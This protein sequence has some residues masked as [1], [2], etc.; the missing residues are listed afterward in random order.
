MTTLSL[1]R[2]V[3]EDARNKGIVTALLGNLFISFDPIFIRLSEVGGVN[4]AFLF[5]L[6]TA[7]SMFLLIQLTEKG[8]LIGT[9]KDS[10]WP[11]LFS[12]L[13]MLTSASTF[14]LSIKYTAVANTV[15]IISCRPVLTA[16]L[17]WVFLREKTSKSL[18]L[19]IGIVLGGITIVVSGSLESG[20]FLGDAL[21][22]V[23]VTAISLNGVLLRKYKQCS[24]MATVGA[25]GLFLAVAM[26]VWAEPA[27][28]SLNTWLIMGVM[29][30][31]TAPLGRVMNAASVRYILASE[32]AM[33]SMILSVLAPLWALMLFGEEPAITTLVGGVIILGTILIYIL[34]TKNRSTPSV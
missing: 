30:L 27:R 18:W 6:F 1:R 20:N 29:G 15:I 3:P 21:A 5:G 12:G 28:F 19:A 34:G 25:G 10:G 2:F 7:I 17:S 16:V 22:L 26:V 13:L 8:G 14:V 23:T 24:R 11:V 4:T 31:L 32:A 33:L 9:L